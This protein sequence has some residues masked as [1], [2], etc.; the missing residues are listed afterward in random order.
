LSFPTGVAHQLV[1]QENDGSD[2]ESSGVFDVDPE[3]AATK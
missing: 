3:D 2:N 1:A